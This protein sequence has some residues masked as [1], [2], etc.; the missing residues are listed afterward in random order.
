MRPS[1]DLLEKAAPR[2][3]RRGPPLPIRAADPLGD[4]CSRGRCPRFCRRPD[5]KMSRPSSRACRR[6]S[7][8]NCEL[9][10]PRRDSREGLAV[11]RRARLAAGRSRELESWRHWSWDS[12]HASA[13]CLKFLDN[14]ASLQLFL[15]PRVHAVIDALP[16]PPPAGSDSKHLQAAGAFHDFEASLRCLHLRAPCKATALRKTTASTPAT[17]STSASPEPHRERGAARGRHLLVAGLHESAA[18]QI[19]SL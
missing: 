12:V 9:Q 2:R 8:S 7:F 1:P 4:P 17:R 14:T 19:G 6:I 18:D 10:A 16:S 13:R 15:K 5:F 3:Q 11:T